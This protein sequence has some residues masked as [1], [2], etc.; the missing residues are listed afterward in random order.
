VVIVKGSTDHVC[1]VL[2]G[3]SYKYVH[4][5]GVEYLRHLETALMGLY[6]CVH[7]QVHKNRGLGPRV[8]SGLPTAPEPQEPDISLSAHL[9]SQIDSM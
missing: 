8:T 4:G 9:D 7:N 3:D 2:D 6:V 1:T 5:G